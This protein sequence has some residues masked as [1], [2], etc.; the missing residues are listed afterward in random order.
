MT[1]Y[2]RIVYGAGVGP[3]DRQRFVDTYGCAR[4]TPQALNVIATHGPIVEIGAGGGQWLHQLRQLGVDAIGYDTF[5]DEGKI[6]GVGQTRHGKS[7]VVQGDE[8]ALAQHQDRTLL[9]VYPPPPDRGGEPCMATR[10]LENY[11]GD[12]LLYVG[13]GRGGTTASSTFFDVLEA[14]WVCSEIVRLDPFPQCC[15]RLFVLRRTT[16]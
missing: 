13:E 15:E 9:L 12:T 2:T 14:E 8:T 11:Q 6:P 5:E 4:W 1:E 7:I 10:C 16:L 3:R